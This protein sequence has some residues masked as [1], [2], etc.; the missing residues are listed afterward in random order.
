MPMKMLIA[1]LA[2]S[3][4]LVAIDAGA[5]DMKASVSIDD[6]AFANFDGAALINGAAGDTNLQF[7]GTVIAVSQSGASFASLS[8]IQVMP[9]GEDAVASLN[10]SAFVRGDAFSGATGV[11]ALNQASGQ[12]NLQVN[13]SAIA[14]SLDGFALAE[15][16]L[17]QT[18]AGGELPSDALPDGPRRTDVSDA[19]FS[20]A[21]GIVQANQVAGFGNK[22]FNNFALSLSAGS[23]P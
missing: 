2:L 11:V 6:N 1:A 23:T 3:F 19:A 18:R 10:A 4:S 7:N 15:S 12:Y 16:E 5:Q 13:A 8:A 21:A 17:V 22:T 20:G 14:I 9:G